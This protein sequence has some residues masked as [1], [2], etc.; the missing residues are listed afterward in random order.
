MNRP[1]A[2][3]A[4][5]FVATLAIYAQTS[6][7]GFIG[8][9][10]DA[11]VAANAIIQQGLGSESVGW[12]FT[13]PHGGNWHPVTGMSHLLD[14]SL[15]GPE[16]G[17]PHVVNALLHALNAILLFLLLRSATGS[18]WA[19]ALAAGLFAVHPLRVESVA[20]ISER[21]DVLS[22][23]FGLASIWSYVVYTR[24]GGR[25]R[26][27]L[28]AGLLALGLMAKPMLVTLPIVYLLID[29]WPLRRMAAPGGRPDGPDARHPTF[30]ALAIEKLPFLALSAASAAMTLVFQ[31]RAGALGNA[32]LVPLGARFATAVVAPFQYLGLT[33]WPQGLS[34][35]V[36][37][38]YLPGGTPHGTG[39]IAGAA[40]AG[41]A[42]TALV[43]GSRR[44]YLVV[45][46]AWFLVTLVPVLG[47]V[48]FG[49]Q[50]IADRYTYLPSIGLAV[51]LAFGLREL[52]NARP[53]L[54]TPVIGVSIAALV[55]L[56]VASHAQAARWRSSIALFESSLAAAPGSGVLHNNLGLAY[57]ADGRRPDAMAQFERAIEIRADDAKAHNNLGKALRDS[58]RLEEAIRHL[59][60]AVAIDPNAIDARINLGVAYKNQNRPT[61]AI[62]HLRKAAELRPEDA[63]VQNNLGTALSA[64]GEREEAIAVFEALLERHP[65]Y[66][67]AHANLGNVLARGRDFEGA[68]PHYRTA[69]ALEPGYHLARL[70]LAS[71]LRGAGEFDEAIGEY[72][73]F[74]AARPDET[75]P[76]LQ[77]AQLL[78]AHPDPAR[79]E[80][81]EA[82][83]LASRAISL[84]DTPS[85][86]AF[87][88][89]SCAYAAAGR[90]ENA[91]ELSIMAADLAGQEGRPSSEVDGHR[92]AFL[93]GEACSES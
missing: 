73:A 90:F 37:H 68:V 89:L 74:L 41:L 29:F 38:P 82:I 17:G 20:W 49:H 70:N 18:D 5:L 65:T 75:L 14:V 30:A 54:R 28:T 46:W 39:A 23:S 86:N 36:P 8:L 91:V 83:S 47:I 62:E 10:D 80:A 25:G 71:A 72:R 22:M 42:I 11:Y 58:G 16:A 13:N 79:R 87:D 19:S 69:L 77:L 40:L 55:A 51:M 21:K 93:Q 2:I 57:L 43:L 15:F 26:Y 85:S 7:F 27:A 4:L 63:A 56:A 35:M 31:E 59:E 33:V 3:C 9:D 12:V 34:V 67:R 84:S 66:A 88:T 52:V 24:E 61:E 45:G 6:G 76:M 48:Q 32:D 92:R 64:A 81:A 44:R 60:R 53:A 1:L 50:G 78:A